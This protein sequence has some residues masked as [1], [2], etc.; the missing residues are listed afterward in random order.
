LRFGL[1]ALDGILGQIDRVRR[2]IKAVV[3]H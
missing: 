1:N 3:T 2:A